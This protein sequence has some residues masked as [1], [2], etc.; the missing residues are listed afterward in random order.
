MD[1]FTIIFLFNLLLGIYYNL[2]V[3]YKVTDK[4]IFGALFSVIAATITIVANFLLIP[5]IGYIGASI[6]TLAAY[7]TMMIL[8][9]FW[10]QKYYP[11]PYETKRI[12][13]YIILAAG[14]SMISFYG[15]RENYLVGM[16][17]LLI[18]F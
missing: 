8:S 5:T 16:I 17:L 15:F 12:L 9:F 6:S 13:I 18:F 2:S 7:G 14:F 3:C 1:I 11:I 4:T 10:G